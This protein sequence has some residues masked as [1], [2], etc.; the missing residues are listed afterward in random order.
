MRPYLESEFARIVDHQRRR[1]QLR[2]ESIRDHAD[3]QRELLAGD[4]SELVRNEGTSGGIPR[5]YR[6]QAEQQQSSGLY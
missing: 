3:M 2:L 4:G 6:R 5:H 1:I